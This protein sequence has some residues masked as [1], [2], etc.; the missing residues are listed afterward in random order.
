MD[1][2]P[3]RISTN[4][5][6]G[7]LAINVLGVSSFFYAAARNLKNVENKR[8]RPA[9]TRYENTSLQSISHNPEKVTAQP[10]NNLLKP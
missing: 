4:F 1:N 7:L 10:L 8:N 5:Y 6:L 2:E 9:T 3:K